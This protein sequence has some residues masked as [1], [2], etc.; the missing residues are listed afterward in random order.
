MGARRLR[1][2]SGTGGS[3]AA[4]DDPEPERM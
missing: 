1:A 2:P 3:D 4:D